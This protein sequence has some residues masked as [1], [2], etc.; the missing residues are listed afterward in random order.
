MSKD[1]KSK[2]IADLMAKYSA[3][4]DTGVSDEQYDNLVAGLVEGNVQGV[5][6][7]IDELSDIAS[8]NGNEITGI[9]A[10]CE[11][12]YLDEANMTDKIFCEYRR[13]KRVYYSKSNPESLD[14]LK[15]VFRIPSDVHQASQTIGTHFTIAPKFDGWAV[16][17]TDFND[18]GAP[19][20][21]I[22]RGAKGKVSQKS[23]ALLKSTDFTALSNIP[24]FAKLFN[25]FVEDLKS[26]SVDENYLGDININTLKLIVSGEL[27]STDG[28]ARSQ[29][30]SIY[31][32]QAV[33]PN[34][35]HFYA[36]SAHVSYKNDQGEQI[37]N[38]YDFLNML[39]AKYER[40]FKNY[41]IDFVKTTLRTLYGRLGFLKCSA[42]S[43]IHIDE[44][45]L[46]E[47]FPSYSEEM[48]EYLLDEKTDIVQIQGTD[49]YYPIDGYAIY[50]VGGEIKG[51]VKFQESDK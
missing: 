38:L 32:S 14:Q 51:Y 45:F 23:E 20:T 27:L 1:T 40:H 5:K 17:L 11:T 10:P 24:T 18:E 30:S 35:L 19:K 2:V 8:E 16:Q 43:N 34:A 49:K 15:Q 22:T 21:L 42:F 7:T 48:W 4:E 12:G 33:T 25:R 3:G 39:I 36:Y 37:I 50:E 44:P 6:L 46:L 13:L 9:H 47:I 31:N 41:G 29:I 28:K 26:C